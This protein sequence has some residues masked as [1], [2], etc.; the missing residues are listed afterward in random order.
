M[1][2]SK[3]SKNEKYSLNNDTVESLPRHS[4][5]KAEYLL[6]SGGEDLLTL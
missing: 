5:G 4:S 2:L 6:R 1:P 3:S